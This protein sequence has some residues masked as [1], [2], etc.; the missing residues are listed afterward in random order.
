VPNVRTKLPPTPFP[1]SLLLLPL[2]QL[3]LFQ[4]VQTGVQLTRRRLSNFASSKVQMPRPTSPSHTMPISSSSQPS[5]MHVIS[6]KGVSLRPPN[7]HFPS[8]LA[9]PLLVWPT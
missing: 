7:L 6:R 5:K 4:Q 1:P 2:L 8:S 9:L 3:T